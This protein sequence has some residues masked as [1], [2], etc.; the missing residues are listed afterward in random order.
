MKVTLRRC[1]EQSTLL[2][3]SEDIGKPIVTSC[4]S[5]KHALLERSAAA[6]GYGVAS[7]NCGGEEQ[8]LR[9]TSTFVHAALQLC[10]P[11]FDEPSHQ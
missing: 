1:R 2:V 5:I 7:L 6:V 11:K 4:A 10:E 8:R 3:G 9:T